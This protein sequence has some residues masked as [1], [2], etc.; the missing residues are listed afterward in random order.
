[1]LS[2]IQFIIGPAG[3]GKSTVC[4]RF[5]DKGWKYI[6]HDEWVAMQYEKKDSGA[7]RLVSNLLGEDYF[8]SENVARKVDKKKLVKVLLKDDDLNRIFVDYFT[9]EFAAAINKWI[10]L[11]ERAVNHGR[12]W[13]PGLVVEFPYYDHSVEWLLKKHPDIVTRHLDEEITEEVCIGRLLRR[14]WSNDRI[15]YTLNLY[16]DMLPK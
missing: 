13:H 5:E 14:G 7:Q 9:A 1:M 10:E 16:Y 3:S 15:Q 6:S 4:R 11:F 12:N 8:I 2:N